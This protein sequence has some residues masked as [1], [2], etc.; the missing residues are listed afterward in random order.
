MLICLLVTAL[1]YIR[2]IFNRKGFGVILIGMPGMEKR[3][4]RFP[5]FYS[6]V[7]F[8]RHYRA[9][10]GGELIFALARHCRSLRLNLGNADLTDVQATASIA[11]ITGGNF[12]PAASAVRADRAHPVELSVVT[13]D[14]VEVAGITLSW[15][16]HRAL[17]YPKK[18]GELGFCYKVA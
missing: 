6:R 8:A 16:P 17:E 14:V 9:L 10:M 2:G 4:S 1:E 3:L 7:G 13:D 12:P 15:A 11:P 5:Q 18:R